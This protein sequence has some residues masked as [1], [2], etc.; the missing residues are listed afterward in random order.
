MFKRWNVAVNDNGQPQKKRTSQRQPLACRAC[1][2]SKVRCDKNVP[3]A[4][5]FRKN[6]PCE[7]ESVEL[8]AK[9]R[10]KSTSTKAES[11]HP[12]VEKL[13]EVQYNPAEIPD[14]SGY[15]RYTSTT[16]YRNATPRTVLSPSAPSD[17]EAGMR[18]ATSDHMIQDNTS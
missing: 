13:H 14:A 12:V 11:H 9:R 8:S 1:T 10:R 3:C 6:T 16:H 2:K 7:R 17:L 5:C 4:R 15:T 18:R